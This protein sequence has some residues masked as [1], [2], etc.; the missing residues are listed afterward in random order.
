MIGIDKI[1]NDALVNAFASDVAVDATYNPATGD[2]VECRVIFEERGLYNPPG[3]EAQVFQRATTITAR[4]D[5]L[6][7]IPLTDET[8]T[9]GLTTYTVQAPPEY[10]GILA[11]MVVK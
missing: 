1:I 11:K 4:V 5:E 2:P 10:D 3:M 6:G 7:Q 9:I 8:F